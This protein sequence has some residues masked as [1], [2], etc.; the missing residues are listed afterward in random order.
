MHN[1]TPNSQNGSQKKCMTD[2]AEIWYSDTGNKR[3]TLTSGGAVEG[4][5]LERD[6]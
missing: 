2:S 3:K 5:L 4:V 6:L 1:P